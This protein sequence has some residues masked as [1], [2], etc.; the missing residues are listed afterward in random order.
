ME[1][2]LGKVEDDTRTWHTS[3]TQEDVDLQTWFSLQQSSKGPVSTRQKKMR[4]GRENE[5]ISGGLGV[6]LRSS[7]GTD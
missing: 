1:G 6:L 7:L 2:V 4:T 5:S 3:Q